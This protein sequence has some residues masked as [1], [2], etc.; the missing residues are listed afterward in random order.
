[1]KKLL[2]KKVL[3]FD[4]DGVLIDSKSNMRKSWIEVQRKFNLQHINF[5]Q[6]FSKI[7]LPFYEILKKLGIK[8][9]Y[10]KIKK[11]Y[12]SYSILYLSRIKFYPNVI[13]TLKY[14]DKAGFLICIV[15]SKDLFRSKIILK[16][17]LNIFSII[18]CPQKNLKGKPDAD[19]INKVMRL[20]KVKPTDCI[21]IGDTKI[22]YL[23]SK[24]SKTDFL[25]AKWGY[26]KK[27]RG[28]KRVIKSISDI[29]KIVKLPN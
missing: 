3:V 7:G 16:K 5:D 10:K 14:L 2:R 15:T 21:Y 19:Q 18:Q 22:D 23:T 28:I 11:C 20:L 4:L 27:T 29:K 9:N 17:H 1:M 26:G 25:F 13:K 8:N 24:N 6:Y 12:D